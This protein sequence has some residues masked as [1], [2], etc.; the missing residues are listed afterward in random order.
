MAG[1]DRTSFIND[2]TRATYRLGVR[3]EASGKVAYPHQ[4]HFDGNDALVTA[5]VMHAADALRYL[6]QA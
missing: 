5:V 3:N 2:T 6:S 1:E 4:P